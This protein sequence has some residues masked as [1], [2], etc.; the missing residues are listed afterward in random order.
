MS[1]LSSISIVGPTNKVEECAE[2]VIDDIRERFTFSDVVTPGQEY[3]FSCWVKSSSSG[4]VTIA[5]KTTDTYTAWRKHV[6]T[7]FPTD[8]SIHITYGIPGTYLILRAKVELGN[9][10]TDW[11]PAPEDAEEGINNAAISASNAQNSAN[12]AQSTADSALDRVSLTETLIEQLETAI[13]MLVT[14]GNGGS[15]MTQTKHGWTFSM[16]G[17]NDALKA[18]QDSLRELNGKYDTADGAIKD[19]NKAVEAQGE[20]ANYV[21]ITTDGNQPSIELGAGNTDFKLRITNTDIR[22]MEGSTVVAYINNQ[23]LNITKAVIKEELQQ[24]NFVWTVRTNGNMGL[25]WKG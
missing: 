17:T 14:D 21:R 6:V 4:S 20:L 10:A 7:F 16:A 18:A 19:L 11:L 1:K 5:G 15:L 22:F 2:F 24:G 25:M 3:T 23:S 9:R 12:S 8:A 13:S